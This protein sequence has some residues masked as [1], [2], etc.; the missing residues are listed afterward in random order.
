M[1]HIERISAQSAYR[2]AATE[3]Y[4]TIVRTRIGEVREGRVEGFQWP[5]EF[6]DRRLAPALRTCAAFGRRIENSASRAQRSNTLLRTR[7]DMRIQLQNNLLLRRME[8]RAGMQM[9]LQETVELL[10]IAAV[11]YYVVSLLSYF[12]G[13]FDDGFVKDQKPLLLAVAVLFVALLFV[14]LH[15]VR[16]R[17][18]RSGKD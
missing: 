7:I 12:L 18:G 17:L 15:Q 9:R 8:E 5:E 14:I 3:A 6:L 13:G 16:R 2:L 11:T 4:A 10:S 1:G